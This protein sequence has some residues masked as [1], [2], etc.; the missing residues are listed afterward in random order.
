MDTHLIRSH[1]TAPRIALALLAISVGIAGCTSS[2]PSDEPKP[3]PVAKPDQ[4]GPTRA[5]M[6]V[7]TRVIADISALKM[8]LDSFAT[9]NAGKYPDSLTVLVMP[10]L[11]GHRYL[12]QST[13]PRDPWNR[14]YVY[15]CDPVNV[16]SYG[17][18][19]VAGGTGDDADIDYASIEAGR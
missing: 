9:N 11:N 15:V 4:P 1:V 12:N 8:G 19:G 5:S 7:R 16:L 13:V 17:R 14:E 6:A 2:K 10:D 3:A 18:D